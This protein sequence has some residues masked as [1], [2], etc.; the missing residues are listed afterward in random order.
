MKTNFQDPSHGA[1]GVSVSG[2]NEHPVDASVDDEVRSALAA[3][4]DRPDRTSDDAA[5]F[6][7]LRLSAFCISYVGESIRYAPDED[8]NR[9]SEALVRDFLFTGGICNLDRQEPRL[10]E[11]ESR[12][13]ALE[14]TALL[15]VLPFETSEG[16]IAGVMVVDVSG[17]RRAV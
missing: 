9:F 3:W 14:A 12:M 4:R 15:L 8:A 11:V 1:D 5:P 17:H 16:N 7:A 10:F 2:V 13:E 6:T